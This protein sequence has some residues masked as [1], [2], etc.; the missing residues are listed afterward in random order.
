M[1]HHVQV[2]LAALFEGLSLPE[3]D[4]EEDLLAVV[5]LHHGVDPVGAQQGLIQLRLV[6]DGQQPPLLV[7]LLDLL[8]LEGLLPLELGEL[9][10]PRVLLDHL[11]RGLPVGGAGHGLVPQQLL[12][13]CH[14]LVPEDGRH[15][16]DLDHLRHLGVGDMCQVSGARL[17]PPVAGSLCPRLTC[18]PFRGT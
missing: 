14:R 16:G 11:E 8:G 4:V 6:P 18:I 1:T 9:L 5:V 3:G 10:Q 13:R 2:Y 15:G 7:R 17:H 12:Q